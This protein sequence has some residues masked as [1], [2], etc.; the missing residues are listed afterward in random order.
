MSDHDLDLFFLGSK[1]EQRQFLQEAVQLV[2]NDHIFWRRNYY[3]KDPPTIPYPVVEGEDARHYKELF[4]TELFSLISDLK[5][6]VPFFSPRYMAHMISESTLPSLVAYYATLLYNPNNVSSEASSV[7][8]RH[9]LEVGK[10]FA[11]LFGFP[12]ERSFGHLASGGTIANYESLW[13]NRAGRFLPVSLALA[14]RN[15]SLSSETTTSDTF[16]EKMNVPLSEVEEDLLS[17]LAEAADTPTKAFALL[18]PFLLMYTGDREFQRLVEKEFQ[19]KWKDPVLILPRTAHYCWSKAASVF[20]LGKNNLLKLDID[21][22]FRIR[23]ESYQKVLEECEAERIPVIQTVLVAGSTEFGSVD[24]IGE[25]VAIREE[26]SA[27]GLYTPIH[28]DAA[29]G[30]YFATMF[31]S[32]QR[33]SFNGDSDLFN[34]TPWLKEAMHAIG[35]CDSVTVDPHKAGFVPYGAGCIVLKHGFLKDVVAETAPY[36]LDSSDT[37][38]SN[39]AMPQLGRFILEGSK[40]GAAAAA[41][42][43]SHQ[44]IP[45][46]MDGYG[47]QLTELCRIARRF[48]SSLREAES[49]SVDGIRLISVNKPHLNIVCFFALPDDASSFSEINTLNAALAGRF[50]IQ[51]VLSIQSYDYLLS[52]TIISK[53]FPY[54]EQQP[55]LTH[56]QRDA[57][58]IDVLRL[59][60]M[61]RWVEKKEASGR[62][63][64][65][66]FHAKLLTEAA[67]T[68]REIR[69]KRNETEET[70]R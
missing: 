3:P 31:Q 7:T 19:I 18:K 34:D 69:S 27:N 43:F 67:R 20:G 16:W 52:H 44:L 54:I 36:I 62:T 35:R 8:I 48:D 68:W 42:W 9:E 25:L 21:E 15:L 55:Q 57:D 4:F 5:L 49:K 61:N 60:F 14:R 70:T 24:P 23:P 10:Q 64:L 1:S 32:G 58:A 59:V 37:T 53:D 47:R 46:N 17:F 26:M 51:D 40:P 41:T 39:E 12:R 45:L 38:S 33:H 11:E 66:E 63:Y 50:G 6:D 22:E 29:F 65:E 56:L 30:G 13:F 28:V 2:L